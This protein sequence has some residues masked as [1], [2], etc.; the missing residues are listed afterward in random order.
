MLFLGLLMVM[1]ATLLF[2]STGMDWITIGVDDL[3][4][5]VCHCSHPITGTV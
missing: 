5:F 1:V 2:A 4:I 3:D